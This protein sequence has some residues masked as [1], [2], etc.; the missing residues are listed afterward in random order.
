MERA[1]SYKNLVK[2]DWL[3]EDV[4]ELKMFE[5]RMASV[6]MVDKRTHKNLSLDKKHSDKIAKV[7]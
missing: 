7:L 2:E 6:F 1:K 4:Q 3:L 5:E